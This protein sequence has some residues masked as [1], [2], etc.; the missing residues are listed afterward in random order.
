[1]KAVA[2]FYRGSAVRTD[3]LRGIADESGNQFY[4]FPEHFEVRFVEQ[5]FSHSCMLSV[6]VT[7]CHPVKIS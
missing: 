2:S 6:T 5:L 7:L 1:M 3:E 4:R